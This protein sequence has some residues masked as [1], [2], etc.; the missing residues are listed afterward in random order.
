MVLKSWR[1]SS[2]MEPDDLKGMTVPSGLRSILSSVFRVY[3]MHGRTNVIVVNIQYFLRYAFMIN[4]TLRS[5]A[6]FFHLQMTRRSIMVFQLILCRCLL[7]TTSNVIHS[8]EQEE[9]RFFPI[10]CQCSQATRRFKS[11][12][13][14]VEMIQHGYTSSW[15]E[16]P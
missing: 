15:R 2:L 4:L 10:L 14:R 5:L 8:R 6:C 1:G 3:G 11:S 9:S 12:A 13:L 16:R 7:G